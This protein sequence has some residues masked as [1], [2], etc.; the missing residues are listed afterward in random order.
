MKEYRMNVP[1]SEKTRVIM[2]PGVSQCYSEG[3]GVLKNYFIELLLVTLLVGLFWG[4]GGAI[5]AASESEFY[6]SPI[7]GLF[8]LG[9]IILILNPVQY[10]EF[11]P[12]LKAVRGEKVKVKDIFIFQELYL[13]VVLASALTAAIIVIGLFF[14]IVP[15]IILACKL[16]FVPYL[17]IDRRMDAVEA[18]KKSWKMTAGYAGTVFLIGLLAVPVFILG[19]ICFFVGAIVSVMWVTCAMTYLYN[20]AD[21]IEKLKAAPPAPPEPDGMAG[22]NG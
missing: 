2:P 20:E 1:Y 3:W 15:G 10:G 9:Y 21:R 5:E 4:I 17:V 19:L 16:A 13:N 6:L 22:E 14:F 12:Y 18:I 11:N 8:Y 7:Y